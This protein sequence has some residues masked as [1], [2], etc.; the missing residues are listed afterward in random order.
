MQYWWL[1]QG[2]LLYLEIFTKLLFLQP[3]M[4]RHENTKMETCKNNLLAIELQM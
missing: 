2:W 1:P 3:S 4:S